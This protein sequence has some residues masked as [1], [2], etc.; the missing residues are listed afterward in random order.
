[1]GDEKFIQNFSKKITSKA[2]FGRL[3]HRCVDNVK[4]NLTSMGRENLSQINLVE[5]R[6]Q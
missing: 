6:D 4:I 5:D 2:L 1:V 3:R